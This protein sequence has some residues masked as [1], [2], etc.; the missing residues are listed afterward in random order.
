MQYCCKL[1]NERTI[2]SF[3]SYI[4]PEMIYKQNDLYYFMDLKFE[5]HTKCTDRCYVFLCYNDEPEIKDCH[6][7]FALYC[8]HEYVN[9]EMIQ[10]MIEGQG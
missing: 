8:K 10:F 6:F 2:D 9:F 3:K 1:L 5:K 4:K 7:T